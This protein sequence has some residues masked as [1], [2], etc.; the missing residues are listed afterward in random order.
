MYMKNFVMIIMLSTSIFAY[1]C[2]LIDQLNY[3]LPSN[4]QM[5]LKIKNNMAIEK[6]NGHIISKYKETFVK[7]VYISNAL[8]AFDVLQIDND[9]VYM[10]H[11]SAGGRAYQKWICKK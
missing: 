2:R 8:M 7:N 1:E 11:Y 6:M 9:I 10:N 5:T 3:S 4:A